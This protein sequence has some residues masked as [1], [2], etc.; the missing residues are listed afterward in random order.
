M[1]LKELKKLIEQ[2]Q[3]EKKKKTINESWSDYGEPEDGGNT[4]SSMHQDAVDILKYFATQYP[5]KPL[6]GLAYYRAHMQEILNFA[7]QYET[8]Q[9]IST[10]T[11]QQELQAIRKM[12]NVKV[13]DY[14]RK[15]LNK[16]G[17]VEEVIVAIDDVLDQA[18]AKADQAEKDVLSQMPPKQSV[19]PTGQTVVRPSLNPTVAPRSRG[20]PKN[21]NDTQP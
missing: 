13:Q 21:P 12:S 1:D 5:T 14:I 3:A 18:I 11:P 19:S 6:T 20:K 15:L 9:G 8:S 4:G 10:D 7:K 2:V 17:L 16:M